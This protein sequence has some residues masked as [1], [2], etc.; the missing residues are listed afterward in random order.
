MELRAKYASAFLNENFFYRITELDELIHVSLLSVARQY[1][2]MIY[3]SSGQLSVQLIA[4]MNVQFFCFA[5]QRC[6]INTRK[7]SS[8]STYFA[9]DCDRGKRS[10]FNRSA[11]L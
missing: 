10:Y 2:T 5:G 6:N 4:M 11:F 7:F 3:P 9:R 1:R 8:P